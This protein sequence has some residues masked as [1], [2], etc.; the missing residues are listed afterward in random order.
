MCVGVEKDE[1]REEK[2]EV[3]GGGGLQ[4][5]LGSSMARPRKG[6]ERF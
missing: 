3:K 1:G 6:E 5:P 2:V 4:D